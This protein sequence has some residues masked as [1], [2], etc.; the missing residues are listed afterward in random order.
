MYNAILVVIFHFCCKMQ[1][2]VWGSISDQGV[3]IHITREILHRVP[4]PLM[5]GST[6]SYGRKHPSLMTLFSGCGYWQ[7]L[8]ESVILAHNKLK[9]APST[10]PRSLSIV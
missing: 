8:I 6:M 3:V 10:Q 5:G 7:E 4:L 1:S 9:V 2:D